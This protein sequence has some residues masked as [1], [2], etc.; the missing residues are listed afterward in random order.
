[1]TV[2]QSIKQT[3]TPKFSGGVATAYAQPYVSVRTSTG[4]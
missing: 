3:L 1:M 2:N 4:A